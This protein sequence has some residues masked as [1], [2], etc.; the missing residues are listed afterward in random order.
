[1]S[2][3]LLLLLGVFLFR[4]PSTVASG[5]ID[6]DYY[7]H[8]GYGEWILDHGR[9]PTQDFWSWTFDGHS[10]RLTQWLGEVLMAVAHR[11]GGET[12]TATLS[13]LLVT[14][15]ITAS[16]KAARCYL[17]HRVSAI[18]IA[19]VCNAL[20]IQLAC[21]PHQFT[22]LGLAVLTWLIADF[23]TRGRRR[24]LYAI[25]PLMAL[26]V[27]L[28]GG[29]AVGL[30]YLAMMVGLLAIDGYVTHRRELLRDQALPLALAAAAGFA[31]T[32]INPYGWEAWLYAIQIAGLKSSAGIVDEW[33][34]T[35]IKAEV[36]L[37]YFMVTSAVAAAMMTARQRP[38]VAQILGAVVLGA[39]GWSAVRL[40]LMASVMMVP[41]LAA[42]FAST[43][44]ATLV[45]QS[46][47]R[48]SRAL[49]LALLV[50]VG[51]LSIGMGRIDKTTER[52]VAEHFPVA[53]V[54]FMKAHGIEGRLLNSPEI[55]GYLIRHLGQKVA[56]DTRLDLY[57]DRPLFE[58]L[59]AMRG[60]LGWPEYIARLSPDV[61]L[62][63]NPAALR[64]L[65]MATGQY[66]LVFEGPS[67]S[68][69]LRAAAR[70]DLPSIAPDSRRVD[71]IFSQLKL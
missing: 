48:V 29:Y 46:P 59:F 28:H 23:L 52:Y 26:W 37:Q 13:A 12:G 66:R 43:P 25:P 34:A 55:G 60:E 50:T 16:Y 5:V 18:A 32:L 67:Y 35:S 54:A 31:A 6:T 11:L 24:S 33:A 4:A 70:P 41:L 36:G 39:L 63:N 9:L 56:I 2:I 30:A 3:P 49:A 7:W 57:G 27:N 40:S 21:R 58:F 1:M 10:Y 15:T 71:V 22:H 45:G 53:E 65:L 47:E 61:I 38:T 20:L 44:L 17:T 64:Q 69:L 19:V 8:L 14:L 51:A 42:A 68:L 62:I